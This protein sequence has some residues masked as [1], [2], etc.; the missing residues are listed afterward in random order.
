V[1]I[2]ECDIDETQ[3]WKRM[4]FKKYILSSLPL[5]RVHTIRNLKHS[6]SKIN[7][8]FFCVVMLPTGH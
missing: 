8:R 4:P 6:I 3:R 1:I 2:G 7:K 5:P